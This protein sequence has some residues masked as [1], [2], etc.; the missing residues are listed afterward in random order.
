[1]RYQN[2]VEV[3]EVVFKNVKM[4]MKKKDPKSDL[5]D[6]LTTQAL[7]SYLKELMAGLTAKVFRTYNA[8]ITLQQ[9]LAKMSDNLE[10]T[11]EKVFFYNRANREVAILCNHQRTVSK[12]HGTQVAKLDDKID[13]LRNYLSDLKAALKGEKPKK[14]TPKKEESTKK[15]SEKEKS[16][17][18]KSS[19]TKS[20][21][22]SSDKVKSED[23][24]EETKEKKRIGHSRGS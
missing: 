7:N 5:F 16:E 11:D 6:E 17:K 2:S 18:E 3:S 12:T 19:K 21:K 24:K 23:G 1:M 15:E 4:F 22:E 14:R 20:E 10:T 8:S 13:E 9:E